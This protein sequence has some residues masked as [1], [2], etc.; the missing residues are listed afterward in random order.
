MPHNTAILPPQ[1]MDSTQVLP[2]FQLLPLLRPQIRLPVRV[3]MP[4]NSRIRVHRS[5]KSSTS[6]LTAFCMR[7]I[8]TSTA[9]TSTLPLVQTSARLQPARRTLGKPRTLVLLWPWRTH[10]L[11][12]LSFWPGILISTLYA[13]MALVSL[14]IKSVSGKR[15][16]SF[17]L[18]R[19]QEQRNSEQAPLMIFM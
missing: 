10:R 1:R 5:L 4:S 12:S 14:G 6:R 9:G 16:S 15:L 7:T 3:L 8:W 2:R 11:P 19:S 13:K 18:K 17:L